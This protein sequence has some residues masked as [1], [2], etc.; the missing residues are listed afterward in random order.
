MDDLSNEISITHGL[1][2]GTSALVE[3]AW[4]SDRVKERS[5]V[6]GGPPVREIECLVLSSVSHIS[7]YKPSL[8]STYGAIL[9]PRYSLTT[10][11]LIAVNLFSKPLDKPKD[12]DEKDHL[13]QGGSV[14]PRTR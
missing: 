8:S 6:G 9:L 1:Y 3:E 14:R 13:S 4:T 7:R 10:A 12:I 11:Y 2:Y 5:W